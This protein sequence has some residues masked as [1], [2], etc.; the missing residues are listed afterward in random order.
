MLNKKR[1]KVQD[2]DTDNPPEYVMGIVFDENHEYV[3]LVKKNRPDALS[4]LLN[5]GGGKRKKGED[6]HKAMRREFAEETGISVMKWRQIA[7]IEVTHQQVVNDPKALVYVF[8]ATLNGP[9]VEPTQ[10]TDEEYDW[11]RVTEL[12]HRPLVHDL[13]W[14]VH[15]AH[16]PNVTIAKITY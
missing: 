7:I 4:G 2:E 10:L 12:H 3:M 6:I 13:L 14:L 1:T 16:D 9:R 8:T 15:M 11:Y 5:G